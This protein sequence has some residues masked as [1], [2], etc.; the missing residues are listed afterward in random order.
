MAKYH[1]QAIE[2]SVVTFFSAFELQFET[3]AEM[4][5]E[6]MTLFFRIWKSLKFNVTCF[7][8][9]RRKSEHVLT[10][11]HV[12]CENCI[13]IFE[14][15]IFEKKSHYKIFKCILCVEKDSVI[16]RIKLV[17]A[18]CRLFNVDESDVRDVMSFEFLNLLQQILKN[19]LLLQNFIDQTF[20]INSDTR[21]KIF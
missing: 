12:I 7:Y 18:N 3:A 20:D 1:C 6:N 15:L 8:C 10:C 19:G 2:K 11:S 4:H 14:N 13:K 16:A 21:T 5:A 17:I 9:F